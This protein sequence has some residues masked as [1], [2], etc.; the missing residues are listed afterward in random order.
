MGPVDTLHGKMRTTMSDHKNESGELK[1][2][3][4]DNKR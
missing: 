4:Q 3:R 2:Q 1:R